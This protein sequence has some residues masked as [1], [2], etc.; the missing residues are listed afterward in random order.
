MPAK[1]IHPIGD[2]SGGV[3]T[4]ANAR[5]IDDREYSKGYNVDSSIPG[6]IRCIGEWGYYFTDAT[7]SGFSAI[8]FSGTGTNDMS[9][10]NSFGGYTG[11]VGVT[12]Y[13]IVVEDINTV[14]STGIS[15]V[16]VG[17]EIN[18][19]V[20]GVNFTSFSAGD[21]IK[22]TGSASNNATY[23]IDTVT[24]HQIIVTANSI[25]NESAGATVIIENQSIANKYK[26]RKKLNDGSYGSYT[27]GITM[28]DGYPSFD[29]GIKITWTNI[30]SGHVVGD[31]WTFTAS[32]EVFENV[33]PG[34]GLFP[35]QT[36]FNHA[37]PAVATEGYY[38]AVA[39][40]I[41]Y[42]STDLEISMYHQPQ[43]DDEYVTADVITIPYAT[44]D[45]SSGATADFIWVD[46]ALRIFDASLTGDDHNFFPHK[47]RLEESGLT[48]FLG[49]TAHDLAISA[50][51]WQTT[52]QQLASPSGG[53]TAFTGYDEPFKTGEVW[54]DAAAMAAALDITSGSGNV[55]LLIMGHEGSQDDTT[56]WDVDYVGWGKDA[57]ASAD[58][59]FYYSY[60]YENSQE[61]LLFKYPN[62]ECLGGDGG[63]GSLSNTGKK[64]TFIPVLN[65][66]SNATNWDTR[67]TGIRL[68]Y[69]RVDEESDVKYF[70]GE[71]P[72]SSVTTEAENVSKYLDDFS[73]Y[74]ALLGDENGNPFGLSDYKDVGIF[75]AEPPTIFTHASMSG[76]RDTT[77]SIACRYK[78][79]T[80]VN[81]RLYVGNIKQK[82]SE[83]SGIEK[84]Y[85]DRIIKSLPNKFDT[86]PDTEFIDVAIRD[87]EEIIKL[88]S[89]GSRL[90]QF[91][92]NT[93]YT[94]AVAGGEE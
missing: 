90:L 80:L 68:Y 74:P 41:L 72:V 73:S 86:L 34:Y 23:T 89:M 70:V 71:F 22:V 50:N 67:I 36:D 91:K 42:A 29:N 44:E 77:K 3:N 38:L 19:Q 52:R 31:A 45:L 78:T 18:I 9:F 20:N 69:S 83:S 11:P 8:A 56:D 32:V 4:F 85:P 26:W 6:E 64:V 33:K 2:Q 55:G 88:E 40:T 48:Y 84:K 10:A 53:K 59:Y 16:N 54:T 63:D 47:W 94:I 17:R 92:Q 7:T 37:S 13:E 46:G 51:T 30:N 1:V 43:L 75:H 62:I 14:T 82:T 58:Y 81:R 27:T 28:T 76:I 15:F 57:K 49:A 5:D 93:L 79:A 65:P 24:S 66:G 39:K 60:L 35:F 12:G 61:S 87:G 25:L 21:I